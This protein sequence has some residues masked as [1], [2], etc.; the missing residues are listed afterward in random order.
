VFSVVVN[1]SNTPGSSLR[2]C[3]DRI[4][5]EMMSLQACPGEMGK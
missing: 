1:Q 2:P 4:V 5:L 3:L